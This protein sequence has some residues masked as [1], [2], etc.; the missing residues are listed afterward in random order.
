LFI[1]VEMCPIYK[2]AEKNIDCNPKICQKKKSLKSFALDVKQSK[3]KKP[4]TNK[5]KIVD[6]VN[7]Q[8]RNKMLIIFSLIK[9]LNRQ[10]MLPARK[11]FLNSI[12]N[13]YCRFSS[14]T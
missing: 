11:K 1:L 6:N 4:N 7:H 10:N 12:T 5:V 2:D 14:I 8:K 13:A 3:V 9:N